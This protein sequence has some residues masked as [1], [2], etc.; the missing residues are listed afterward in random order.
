[1]TIISRQPLTDNE[2]AQ[3]KNILAKSHCPN[4]SLKNS[5]ARFTALV[6]ENI[7]FDDAQFFTD[8]ERIHTDLKE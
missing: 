7:Y 1:M 8:D 6:E 3:V 4:E 5:F 2:I